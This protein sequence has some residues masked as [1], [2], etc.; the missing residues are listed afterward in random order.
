MK[1]AI[2]ICF[3]LTLYLS[4]AAQQ[5]EKISVQDG[6]DIAG[7]LTF[8][9]IY[10]YPQF[11]IGRVFFKDE[12]SATGLLN[13]NT[14][15]DEMQ[16]VAD[17][18][19]TLSLANEHLIK[20][21][22]A[23]SD[24]FYYYNKGYYELITSNSIA[25]LLKKQYLKQLDKEKIGGYGMATSSSAI[26]TYNSYMADNHYV[27]LTVRGDVILAKKTDYFLANKNNQLL[28]AT[29]KSVIKLFPKYEKAISQYVKENEV[30]FN[31]EADLRNLILFL[32][33]TAQM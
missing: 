17:T 22:T 7:R 8:D 23:G 20:Y 16:F 6:G 19:D 11:I 3:F 27:K 24:S 31:K 10:R 4:S 15:L 2:A 28:P 25:R 32:Q 5:T 12:T 13:Y 26:T 29:K 18:G 33:R 1:P 14:I 9:Q 21:I 30:D